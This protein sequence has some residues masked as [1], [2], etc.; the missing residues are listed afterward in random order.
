MPHK[1]KVYTLIMA[2]NSD[3]EAGLIP[4]HRSRITETNRELQLDSKSLSL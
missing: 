4:L 2:R 3:G 1:L